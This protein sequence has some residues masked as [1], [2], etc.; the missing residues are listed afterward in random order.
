V[1]IW[2]A[3]TGDEVFTVP[4]LESAMNSVAWSPDGNELLTASLDGTIAIWPIQDAADASRR[5]DDQYILSGHTG[6]VWNASWSPDGRRI[7][8]ASKDG[9]AR[10][11]NAETGESLLSISD[12][13]GPVWDA[14]WSPTGDRIATA[15]EDGLV[16]I[17]D[18]ATGEEQ[19]KLIGHEG[20]LAGVSWSPSGRE[21]AS[22]GWDGTARVWKV[23]PGTELLA[24]SDKNLIGSVSWS[25]SG[26]RIIT[27]GGN[28][29]DDVLDG[30]VKVWDADTGG[31]LMTLVENKLYTYLPILSPDGAR[32]LI[33][34]HDEGQELPLNTVHVRDVETGEL[35]AIL[36]GVHKLE[37]FAGVVRDAVWSPDGTRIADASFDG[38]AAVYDASTGAVL[39]TLK[40]HEGLVTTI[41]WSPD[42][43]RLVTGDASNT[44]RIW[45]VE[46]GAELMTLMGTQ[47][48]ISGVNWVAWSPDGD[49]ILTTHGNPE[50]GGAD[51]STRIWDSETGELLLVIYG[52]TGCI[53]IG[54]WS[55]NEQRIFTA[56]MDGTI[57]VWDANSGAEILKLSTPTDWNAFA[58]WSPVGTRLVTAND[59]NT[60]QVWR[61]W[62]TT[63]ELIEHAYECC[64]VRQFTLE[65]RAQYGLPER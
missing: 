46:T 51:T 30:S 21:L 45:D 44:T 53:W 35:L 1:I 60:A 19:L 18:A 9:T 42:G 49:R 5:V 20:A 2:D 52:H 4:G 33:S 26:D 17:W 65:E 56:S 10:I 32:I 15:H 38:T 34:E 36:S 28:F 7:L 8:S 27:G 43:K 59:K 13:T 64:V 31:V 23:T 62:Q 29:S 37:G 14:T 11:W 24:L 54:G 25:P 3:A 40:V 50:V 22:A 16:R 47:D 58:A 41:D 63:G 6:S 61:V 48:G 55:P 12:S 57:R 39:L